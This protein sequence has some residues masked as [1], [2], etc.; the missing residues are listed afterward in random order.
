LKGS[1]FQGESEVAE[2]GDTI[3]KEGVS[4]LALEQTAVTFMINAMGCN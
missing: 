2:E 3:E 4:M 1:M